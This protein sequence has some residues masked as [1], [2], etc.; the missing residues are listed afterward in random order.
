MVLKDRL[1]RGIVSLGLAVTLYGCSTPMSRDRDLVMPRDTYT[2]EQFYTDMEKID[3]SN[4]DEQTKRKLHEQ[5]YSKLYGAIDMDK[6]SEDD[7]M[8][9]TSEREVYVDKIKNTDKDFKKSLNQ[10]LNFE[11]PTD[12]DIVFYSRLSRDL[13]FNLTFP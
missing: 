6:L 12:K 10:Y 11:N 5:G 1:S 13:T 2:N 9:L 7:I 8:S 4:F 3:N